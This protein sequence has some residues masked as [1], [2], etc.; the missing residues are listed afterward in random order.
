MTL[1]LSLDRKAAARPSPA[2]LLAA[3]LAGLWLLYV[4]IFVT[5]GGAGPLHAVTDAAA[6]VAPLAGL[7]LA[8]RALVRRLAARAVWVQAAG[9]VALAFA[10]ALAWYG[11]AVILLATGSWLTGDGFHIHGFSG[12]ALAWQAFQGVA[13]YS[14]F[15]AASYALRAAPAPAALSAETPPGAAPPLERYLIRQGEDFRPVDV[16]DIVAIAGAQDYSEVST[17]NG[18]HLVRMSLGEFEA[19]LDPARFIRVHRSA[20]IQLAFLERAEPAGG[21]RMLAHMTTGE[22]V[23]ISR[24]GVKALRPLIV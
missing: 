21:G 16:R 3:G 13:V 20:I 17:A 23:P 19:R 11:A 24:N 10:F 18:R 9:H 14:A 15:A 1:A 2:A 4:A 6:N 7:A 5:T 8:T 12:V 22:R